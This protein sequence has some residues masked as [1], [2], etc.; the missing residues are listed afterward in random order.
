MPLNTVALE[1]VPPNTDRSLPEQLDEAITVA[2]LSAETGIAEQVGHD[3]VGLLGGLR[4]AY[5]ELFENSV[6]N[7]PPYITA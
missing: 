3:L 6:Q 2:H 7:Q 1:M 5:N 4:L